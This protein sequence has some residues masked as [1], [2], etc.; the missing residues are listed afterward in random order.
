MRL[1]LAVLLAALSLT[2]CAN[3]GPPPR[4]A[5]TAPA[6]APAASAPFYLEWWQGTGTP[7]VTVINGFTG[8]A[9]AAIAAPA[10]AGSFPWNPRRTTW[11]PCG[12]APD[13]RTFLLCDTGQYYELRLGGG[14]DEPLDAVVV[15]FAAT[16][17]D[18][19]YAFDA[20]A[21]SAGA[22]LWNTS[23]LPGGATA[24]PYSAV[25]CGDL[26]PIIGITG[27]PVIDPTTNTMYVVNYDDEGRQSCLPLACAEYPDRAG[28]KPAHRHTSIST[29][30]GRRELRRHGQLQ[31]RSQS[32][33][34]RARTRERESLYRLLLVL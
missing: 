1:L 10:G 34:R 11:Y 33:A 24:V 3:A 29:G 23:L 32:A 31:C 14:G 5:S 15:V 4:P 20:D 21:T 6:G 25:S 12:A 13:D 30:D 9:E 19:V 18:S 16:E 17:N 28:H 2:G 27:T 26:T 22:P 8:Q 7:A